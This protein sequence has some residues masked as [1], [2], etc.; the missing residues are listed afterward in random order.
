MIQW[1]TMMSIL[2][3]YLI[4]FSEFKKGMKRCRYELWPGGSLSCSIVPVHQKLWVPSLSGHN[5][6]LGLPCP[7]RAHAGVNQSMFLSLISISVLL[8]LF[9]KSI[10]IS[11]GDE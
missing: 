8:P 7:V 9:L 2:M 1:A 10:N 6:R 4:L 11:L 5:L 3:D